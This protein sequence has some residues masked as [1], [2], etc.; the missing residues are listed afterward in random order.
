M[1]WAAS[2]EDTQSGWDAPDPDT[3]RDETIAVQ[4]QESEFANSFAQMKVER[5]IERDRR[6]PRK[7]EYGKIP[8]LHSIILPSVVPFVPLASHLTRL[9]CPWI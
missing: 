5:G 6:P 9:C 1:A 7:R 2:A 3:R 8:I 4:M